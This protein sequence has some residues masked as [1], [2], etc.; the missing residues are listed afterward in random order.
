MEMHNQ[1]MKMKQDSIKSVVAEKTVGPKIAKYDNVEDQL[2]YAPA[3]KK[4][5]GYVIHQVS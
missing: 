4:G 5:V 2:E 1:L 3:Y